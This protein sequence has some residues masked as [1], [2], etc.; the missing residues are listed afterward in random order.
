MIG[1][2]RLTPRL[3]KILDRTFTCGTLVSQNIG[4]DDVRTSHLV[5]GENIP[6][7]NDLDWTLGHTLVLQYLVL[8]LAVPRLLNCGSQERIYL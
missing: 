5:V 1:Y 6:S 7:A 8:L 2:I 4:D 3:V